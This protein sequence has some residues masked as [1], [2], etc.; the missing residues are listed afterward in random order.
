MLI[1]G[2]VLIAVACGATVTAFGSPKIDEMTGCPIGAR[3][4][5]AHTIILVDETD[6][7]SNDELKYTRSLI[8]TEYFWLPIG[9][10]LTVRSIV[11]DPE[12]AGDIVVCRISD[13]S[14]VLGINTNPKRLERDFQRIAG[15]KLE[16]LYEMLAHASPQEASPILE[17]VAQTMD[18]PDFGYSVESRR[19][20]VISDFAQHSALASDYSPRRRLDANSQAQLQRDMSDVAVRLHYI[21]RRKLPAVQGSGHKAFWTRYFK[22]MG[23]NVAL[24]HDL[25]I[26]E[27]R[28]KETWI[29][30]TL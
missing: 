15:A 27:D 12:Q 6:S 18:R 16:Q 22:D 20:V 8:R 13:G 3:A 19:L 9:G 28:D 30:E 23:A 24:G 17:N 11:A 7:L 5:Q 14:D 21:A 10:R 1:G 4:P 2:S 26:G 29:D 25:L